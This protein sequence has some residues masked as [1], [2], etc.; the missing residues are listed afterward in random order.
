M[1]EKQTYTTTNSESQSSPTGVGRAVGRILSNALAVEEA[2]RNTTAE[3]AAIPK[4]KLDYYPSDGVVIRTYTGPQTLNAAKLAKEAAASPEAN[5][6][7]PVLIRAVARRTDGTTE[8][9]VIFFNGTSMIGCVIGKDGTV[10]P[11]KEALVDEAMLE[12]LPDI[13]IGK[14]WTSPFGNAGQVKSV[15]VPHI[16][17]FEQGDL[18][19]PG[20]RADARQPLAYAR[21]LL[22]EFEQAQQPTRP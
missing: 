14:P 19:Y 8:R 16:Q 18:S 5:D 22:E 1:I 10:Q 21:D 2:R 11:A 17:A 9:R 15:S 4:T 3:R 20:P 6:V 12:Q 13:E 7:G